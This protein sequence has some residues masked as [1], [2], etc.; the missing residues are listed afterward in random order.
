[1]KMDGRLSA[2][3]PVERGVKE[4]L[5][6]LPVLFLLVMDP[7][8]RQSQPTGLGLCINNF[9]ARGFMHADDIITL[10]TSVASFEAQMA[11]MDSNAKNS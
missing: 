9:Y 6:L 7:L 3:Y 2:S 5:M 4:E 1:M 11:P 8:L 10:A